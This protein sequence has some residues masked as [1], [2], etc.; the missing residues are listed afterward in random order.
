MKTA[1]EITSPLE[2]EDHIHAMW[3][4]LVEKSVALQHE[5]AMIDRRI[6]EFNAGTHLS[7]KLRSNMKQMS[8]V[9]A[10]VVEHYMSTI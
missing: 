1:L 8:V 6:W 2:L 4:D 7:P 9:I 5:L 3:M 10:P